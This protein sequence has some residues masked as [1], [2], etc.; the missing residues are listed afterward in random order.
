MT[1]PS[2]FCRWLWL[3]QDPRKWQPHMKVSEAELPWI[4]TVVV[5]SRTFSCPSVSGLSFSPEASHGN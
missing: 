2:L 3:F 5:P 4:F 1:L